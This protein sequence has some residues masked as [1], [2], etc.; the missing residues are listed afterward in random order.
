LCL[1]SFAELSAD[2]LTRVVEVNLIGGRS[3]VMAVLPVM[4]PGSR[5]AL[6]ATLAGF[7]PEGGAAAATASEHGTVGLAAAARSSIAPSLR[8]RRRCGSAATRALPR[9]CCNRLSPRGQ[10]Q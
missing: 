4:T 5:L 3:F 1:E 2:E 6:V 7:V 10:G 8:A 9:G